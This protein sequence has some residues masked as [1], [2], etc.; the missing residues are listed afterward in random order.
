MAQ[1]VVKVEVPMDGSHQRTGQV[2]QH[3][4][5]FEEA[6]NMRDSGYGQAEMNADS[7]QDIAA[8]QNT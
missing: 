3:C 4:S 1:V 5:R 6:E 8:A 7:Q 2:M